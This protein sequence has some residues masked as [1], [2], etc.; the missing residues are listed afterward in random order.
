MKCHTQIMHFRNNLENHIR[1]KKI[2]SN[3]IFTKIILDLRKT[4]KDRQDIQGRFSM[5]QNTIKAEDFSLN[6]SEFE[7]IHFE[8]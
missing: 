4:R 6:Q 5:S 7:P 8:P 1:L 3:F 2:G